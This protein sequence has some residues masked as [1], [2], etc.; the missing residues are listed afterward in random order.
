MLKHWK[1]YTIKVIPATTIVLM[2]V[3][4]L[5]I[6]NRGN[7]W[8]ANCFAFHHF[9]NNLIQPQSS[10]LQQNCKKITKKYN[11]FVWQ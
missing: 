10:K 3:L 6:A 2:L 9:S 5:E 4:A 7:G 1:M 8:N 11:D